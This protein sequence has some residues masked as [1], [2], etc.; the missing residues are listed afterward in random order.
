MQGKV[1]IKATGD[2]DERVVLVDG[3]ETARICR[4]WLRL[5]GWGW[6]PRDLPYSYTSKTQR[7][8]ARRA[9]RA[10][11]EGRIQGGAR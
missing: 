5:G 6:I 7:E 1:T 8:A 2:E 11:S 4:A 3:V 10:V 9:L